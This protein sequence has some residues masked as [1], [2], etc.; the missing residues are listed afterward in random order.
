MLQASVTCADP[1]CF[2]LE[3][4]AQQCPYM[5]IKSIMR[6]EDLEAQTGPHTDKKKHNA[7]TGKDHMVLGFDGECRKPESLGSEILNMLQVGTISMRSSR[8]SLGFTKA[9]D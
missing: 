9:V 3:T 6:K 4:Q 5:M 1:E 2:K 8:L 7:K